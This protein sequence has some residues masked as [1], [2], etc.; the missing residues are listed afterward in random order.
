MIPG[1][2]ED[3]SSARSASQRPRYHGHPAPGPSRG[4]C[5]WRKMQSW[6]G[7]R[8]CRFRCCG[9]RSPRAGVPVTVAGDEVPLVGGAGRGPAAV[10]ALCAAAGCAR[11]EAAA[12]LLT[13]PFG[14][15]D[16][17][18]LRRLRRALQALGA[19]AGEAR[20]GRRRWTAAGRR[21][22]DPRQPRR[23]I[24]A[25]RRSA[26][27]SPRLSGTPAAWLS[28]RGIARRTA[29]ARRRA[30][31]DQGRQRGGR[32]LVG[33]GAVRAGG[34]LAGG[35]GRGGARGAAADRDLDAVS[36]C[37]MRP[38]GAAR[39]PPGAPSLFLESLGQEI[40][41]DTLAER[42]AAGDAV[43]VLTAHRSKG[44]EWDVVVVAGV[45]EGSWPD[46][47]MRA[48]R[49]SAGRAC[50]RGGRAGRT[51]AEAA[52]VGRRHQAA[53]RGAAAVLRRRD[54]GAA[55]DGGHR[56]RRRRHRGAPVTFPARLAGDDIADRAGRSCPRSL[57]LTAALVASL[58]PAAADVASRAGCATRR[59]RVWRSSPRRVS[60]A[61][62]PASGTRSPTCPTLARSPAKVRP[63]GCHRHRWSRSPACGL[64]LAARSGYRRARA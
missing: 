18:G 3:L 23:R 17:L 5:A 64:A 58:R 12:E 53:R 16:A 38:P 32:S 20:P 26:T 63:S 24:L 49:C 4:R 7:R 35:L 50:R 22:R 8:V 47:R 60:A 2:V 30:A 13:G 55:P 34:T 42:A 31:G 61:R 11:Q 51:A 10:A 1:E 59:R 21:L 14:G 54:A 57:A 33:V 46:L 41:G 48:G 19:D 37:S 28:S 56:G 45:Q 52:A 36:R 43:R 15:T 25:R 44:L 6:Y 62:T 40:P 27:C 9:G 29:G 39:L